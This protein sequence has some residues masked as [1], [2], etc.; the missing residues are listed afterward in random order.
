MIIIEVGA[1][2]GQDTEKF[3]EKPENIVY[4][5]EPIPELAF[6]LWEKHGQNKNFHLITAAIDVENGWKKFNISKGGDW[7]C[8]SLH[9]FAPDL[10]KVWSRPDFRYD[11]FLANAMCIRLDTFMDIFNIQ[12]IGYIHIDAQGNDFNV[13]KS[14]GDKINVVRS[15]VVEVSNKVELY[16]IKDNHVS[17]VKPWLEERGFKTRVEDDGVGKPMATI[18]GNEVN[19]FFER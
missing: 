8:S 16:D 4:S 7:G 9:D 3:L 10:H 17:V 12:E 15:G 1:N 18:N 5:F 14:L 13:L 6:R 11:T 19:V 2:Q